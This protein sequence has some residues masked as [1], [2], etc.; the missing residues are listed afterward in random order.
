MKVWVKQSKYA[1][2]IGLVLVI[3]AT[4]GCDY[5]R[6]KEDEA[7]RTY[8]TILPEMPQNSVPHQDGKV[9]LLIADPAKLKNPLPAT[10]QTVARGAERYAVFCSQCHGPDGEGYGTVGQSFAPLPT[11]LRGETVR[12]QSDGLIFIR[13]SL[14]YKRQPPLYDT[15]SANDR[16]AIIHFLRDIEKK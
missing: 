12:K 15:V 11:D 14:G 10:P 1:I 9:E 2:F 5:A 4:G 16:W 13:I 8:E 7:V 3:C 6:M